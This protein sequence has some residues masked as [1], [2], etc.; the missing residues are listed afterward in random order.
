MA[1]ADR[2]IVQPT[3]E[4]LA[5]MY[6][7]PRRHPDLTAMRV[8]NAFQKAALLTLVALIAVSFAISWTATLIVLNGLCL[9][10]YLA[11]VAFKAY[12]IDLSVRA[13]RELSFGAGD[14]AAL[15]DEELPVYTI[16]VPLYREA[17]SLPR[18][19]DGLRMLDYPK[20]KLDILLLL[21][22]DDEET[23]RAVDLTDLPRYVR[24]VVTPDAEPKTKPKACNL[25]LALARGEQLVIYDAEDRPEPDQLKKAVL[26]FRRCGDEVVC[27][28]AKL[29]FYNRR[30]NL[31]T[32]WFTT[33]Y[34]IWFDLFLPGL[35]HLDAPIPLGGTSNHFRA[36]EL[37]RLLGWDPYNVTEDCEL[38]VRLALNGRRTRMMDSTT[39]EE[40]CSRLDYWV[41]QR[42]RWTKG[43]I[44]TYLAQQRRPFRLVSRLGL[45]RAFSFH[46]MV[47]GTFLCLLINPIYWVLALLWFTFRWKTF[48]ELFPYPLI[49]WGL[50]CLFVGNFLFVYGAVLATCKR[51]YYDLV[52]YCLLMPFYW[53]IT[54][55]G[56]WKGFAQLLVRPSYWEKTQHGLDLEPGAGLE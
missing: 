31:L 25:G 13:G 9:A 32:R 35:D 19:L 2:Q 20:D 36:A 17:E 41:R 33:D 7:F 46:V 1:E 37:R 34:A 5:F 49:L 14:V 38:G 12:L 11:M 16:L 22:E 47:G 23:R 8:T 24:V 52:K 45:A 44:Q 26:G 21:E 39:W 4:A 29:D 10:F 56:A 43:Y 40:A 3:R 27:L 6:A 28:Q 48:G 51:G 15:T 18:L 54:S 42:S 55:V 30:Q 50:I 53:V